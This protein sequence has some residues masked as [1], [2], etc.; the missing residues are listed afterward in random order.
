MASYSTVICL[1]KYCLPPS[2]FQRD[3]TLDGIVFIVQLL[4]MPPECLK[5]QMIL[6]RAE[7]LFCKDC[8]AGVIHPKVISRSDLDSTL[9][10]L[11]E[12]LDLLAHAF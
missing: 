12:Y 3:S 5:W 2:C 10:A 9:N 11:L 6:R 4:N 7:I 1:T 8:I